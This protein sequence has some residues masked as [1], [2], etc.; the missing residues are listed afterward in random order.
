MTLSG[1]LY[2]LFCIIINCVALRCVLCYVSLYILQLCCTCILLF[3]IS[4]TMV[5]TLHGTCVSFVLNIVHSGILRIMVCVGDCRIHNK[6]FKL[7]S[8]SNSKNVEL[9]C[10]LS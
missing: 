4:F 9:I 1:R 10:N 5:S 3:C 2:A 8:S 6:L 7:E